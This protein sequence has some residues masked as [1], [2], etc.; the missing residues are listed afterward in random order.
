MSRPW[1]AMRVSSLIAP[2]IL[3]AIM[4]IAW[5]TQKETGSIPTA[6]GAPTMQ[7]PTDYPPVDRSASSTPLGTPPPA[8]ALPGAFEFAMTHEGTEAP[9]TWDPCRPV[10][11]V[12]NPA[13]APPG[14]E[15]LVHDA[16]QRTAAATGLTFEFQGPTDEVNTKQREAYQPD[17]YDDRWAPLLIS[18]GTEQDQP[19]LAGYIAG[20]GGPMVGSDPSGRLTSV[21]GTVLLDAADL[22]PAMTYPDGPNGVRAVIQ[23]ELGHAMGLDHVA[24]P[25]QLMHSEGG[26]DVTDWGSGDLAGLHALGSGEC[27]PEV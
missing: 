18:W 2:A 23:H 8:P 16:V 21:S 6:L 15:D 7:R 27:A 14:T 1:R 19:G 26:S 13:G 12:I 9:V 4:G 20:L 24:D 22:G 10:R 17:R 3:I 11:Y 5:Y 25:Q